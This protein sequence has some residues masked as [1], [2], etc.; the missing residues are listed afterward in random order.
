M[1]FDIVFFQILLLPRGQTSWIAQLRPEQHQW[2]PA[3]CLPLPELV[4]LR[5]VH[6]PSG[7]NFTNLFFVGFGFKKARLFSRGTNFFVFVKR[8]SFF[9]QSRC[10]SGFW[11]QIFTMTVV[12]FGLIF[13]IFGC[14]LANVIPNLGSSNNDVTNSE[15]DV[16]D[17][18]PLYLCLLLHQL[19][20]HLRL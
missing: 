18:Q 11:N 10:N 2:R 5:L 15:R 19:Y 17:E 20:L 4:S 3:H 12:V 13:Y 6:L 1:V 14:V 9:E 8:Y 16:I 7:L